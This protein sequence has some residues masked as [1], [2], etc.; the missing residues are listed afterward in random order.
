[1]YLMFGILSKGG[2]TSMNKTLKIQNTLR[3]QEKIKELNLP[4][5]LQRNKKGYKGY[6]E[7]MFDVRDRKNYQNNQVRELV[8]W[9]E[10]EGINWSIR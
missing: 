7:F 8:K 2:K 5:Q 6:F 9:A 3:V 10:I 1:M 4:L